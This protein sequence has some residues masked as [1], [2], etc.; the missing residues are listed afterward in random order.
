MPDLNPEMT[1]IALDTQIDS[2]GSM[3]GLANPIT[4]DEIKD[5][6]SNPRHPVAQREQALHKLR[7]EMVSR[8]TADVEAG[9]GDL[10]DEVD[11]GLAILSQ[12]AEGS[13]DPDTLRFRDTAV[14]PENL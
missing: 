13:A 3:P 10:I 4:V 8:D 1:T 2:D 11:R 14:N 6:Y 5:I 7:S 12:P 9:L